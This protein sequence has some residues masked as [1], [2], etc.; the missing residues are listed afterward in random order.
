MA[1]KK[2]DPYS[3]DH[4]PGWR[5]Y[6]VLRPGWGMY[7]DVRRRLP[8]YRS[9]I[10]DA[11]TYRTFAATVRIFF[12]KYVPYQSKDLEKSWALIDND[13]RPVCCQP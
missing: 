11:W 4:Q 7:H 1:T 12:V 8:Y 2:A 10:T 5:G 6:R 13:A 9:D 3:F